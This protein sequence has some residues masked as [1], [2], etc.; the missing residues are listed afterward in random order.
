MGITGNQ[1]LDHDHVI[2]ATVFLARRHVLFKES[3]NDRGNG[4]LHN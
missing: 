1:M 2:L 4:Y 3:N